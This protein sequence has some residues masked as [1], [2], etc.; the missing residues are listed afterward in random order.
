MKQVRNETLHQFIT[1]NIL[2]WKTYNDSNEIR[3]DKNLK[4]EL[5]M[6][7]LL[8]HKEDVL[9]AD[10]DF[11]IVELIENQ[12]YTLQ[13]NGISFE[14][15]EISLDD[16]YR[17][18][19]R[20][21]KYRV[22]KKK[23]IEGRDT[24][25]KQLLQETRKILKSETNHPLFRLILEKQVEI[26]KM[27]VTKTIFSLIEGKEPSAFPLEASAF[28]LKDILLIYSLISLYPI[29][30]YD[31]EER[32]KKEY[33]LLPTENLQIRNFVFS[34]D[35][36]QRYLIEKKAL[37]DQLLNL[38]RK[39]EEV[40]L[41][42]KQI[43]KR[44]MEFCNNVEKKKEEIRLLEQQIKERAS[45]SDV[46]NPALL[47]ALWTS[48]ING[49]FDPST[50]GERSL[51]TLYTI[52]ENKIENWIIISLKRLASFI[53]NEETLKQFDSK[54]LKKEINEETT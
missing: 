32:I 21:E 39:K 10:I 31:K 42:G 54:G 4:I 52:K 43:T 50:Q 46:L 44:G 37:E 36:L 14:E 41:R 13:E 15:Q 6:L 20:I 3:V 12:N 19:G 47:S 28:P 24:N 8:M 48:L 17:F 2:F 9:R 1:S 40:V 35:L 23:R 49:T 45:A 51:F 26:N 33:L 53:N 30:C 16:L 22:E 5:M 11:S 7:Y 34:D 18:V 38:E 25:P 27:N 29:S